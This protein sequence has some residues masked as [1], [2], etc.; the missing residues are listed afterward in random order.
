MMSETGCDGVVV[1]RGCLGRPWLFAELQA[2]LRGEPVPA[3]PDLGRVGEI[4]YRHAALLADHYGEDRGLRD[5]RKHMAW[6]LMGFPVGA[7]LRRRFASVA[8]L[9]ELQDLIGELDPT[10]PFPPTPRAPA[11]AKAPPARS[12]SP[13]AGSTTPKT[14]PSPPPP[15]SCTRADNPLRH[16]SVRHQTSLSPHIPRIPA[17]ELAIPAQELAILALR[18]RHPGT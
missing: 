1:G 10:A 9:T 5:L 12:A 4:L 8:T 11:A 16:H 13:T 17:Q 15:T 7:D 3:G 6:Y 2:A 14:P 18:T